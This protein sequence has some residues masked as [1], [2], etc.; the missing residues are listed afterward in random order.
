MTSAHE[1]VLELLEHFHVLIDARFLHVNLEVLLQVLLWIRTVLAFLYQAIAV[2]SAA[3][4]S[5]AETHPV[6]VLAE[7]ARLLGGSSAAGTL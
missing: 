5:G 3:G 6:A 7:H 2:V 1:A 4:T